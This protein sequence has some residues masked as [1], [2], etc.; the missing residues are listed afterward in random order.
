MERRTRHTRAFHATLIVTDE[1]MGVGVTGFFL[2][3]DFADLAS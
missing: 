2:I 3:V 1:R